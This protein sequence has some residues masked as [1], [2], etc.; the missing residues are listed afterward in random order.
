MEATSLSY[1]NS[2]VE[3]Q[4]DNL[5]RSTVV[6]V[7]VLKL[8]AICRECD[9]IQMRYVTLMNVVGAVLSLEGCIFAA[10]V[11]PWQVT[12]S[13]HLRTLCVCRQDYIVAL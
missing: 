13:V 4:S 7:T 12:F 3:N 10:S 1:P 8:F 9:Q 2:K 5:H 11:E 6:P